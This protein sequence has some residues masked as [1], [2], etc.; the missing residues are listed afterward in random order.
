METKM[1][2]E[3]GKKLS[4]TLA[5]EQLATLMKFEGVQER[6]V[7]IGLKNILQDAHAS[8]ARETCKSDDDYKE[9]SLALSMKALQAML[10][11]EVRAAKMS[12]VRK[13]GFE[14]ILE[15]HAR[16]RIIEAAKAKG[17]TDKDMLAALVKANLE[18][19]SA[20]PV[21][22]KAA[23]DEFAAQSVKLDLDLDL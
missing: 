1:L 8:I 2:L 10:N 7:R 18:K 3:I 12:A 16:K 20:N 13:S 4:I 22:V 6:I 11:G 23:Q 17:V 5:P 19:A 14:A 9:Q 15:R 21:I